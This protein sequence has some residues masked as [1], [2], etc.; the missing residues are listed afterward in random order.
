MKKY[1]GGAEDEINEN[2]NTDVVISGKNSINDSLQSMFSEN[3]IFGQ[4]IKM[5]IFIIVFF[6]VGV[7][8]ILR[9]IWSLFKKYTSDDTASSKK[10][11]D[12]EFVEVPNA[13]CL[14][15][16]RLGNYLT[17]GGVFHMIIKVDK[18]NT[19]WEYPH[20][21]KYLM[22]IS[23]DSFNPSSP[24]Q[25]W[26]EIQ[27]QL[28]GVWIHPYRNDMIFVMSDMNSDNENKNTWMVEDF[29]LGR[30][31]YLAIGISYQ[32]LDIFIDGNLR[33]SA[34]LNFNPAAPDPTLQ[35]F[36]R[37]TPDEG[38]SSTFQF[39]KGELDVKSVQNVAKS[40]NNQ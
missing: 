29:P 27:N 7:I 5:N 22:L 37:N 33:L 12:S 20:Q 28:P 32:R 3:G 26:S 21:W 6:L 15:N 35:G 40:I 9:I 10:E 25:C 39:T 1:I 4:I 23:D 8:T 38:I 18:N 24:P 30:F 13:N 11:N 31:F 16:D 34:P 14:T 17:E 19:L 2:N 36:I